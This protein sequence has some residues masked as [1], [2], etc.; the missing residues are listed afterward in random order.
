[1]FS[2]NPHV[3]FLW[4]FF[5]FTYVFGWNSKIYFGF[6]PSKWCFILTAGIIWPHLSAERESPL[7]A[8]T[9]HA[10]AAADSAKGIHREHKGNSEYSSPG[11]TFRSVYTLG[12]LEKAAIR[13]VFFRISASIRV[14]PSAS[15]GATQI[16]ALPNRK[17]TKK[18]LMT[19]PLENAMASD[20]TVRFVE[21]RNA[22]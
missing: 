8:N 14:I 5:L 21:Y 6:L 13:D 1:M 18:D 15:S 11:S 10:D 22:V 17:G 4:R 2:Y 3:Y 20:C 12:R 9:A 7:Y 19:I 16:Y